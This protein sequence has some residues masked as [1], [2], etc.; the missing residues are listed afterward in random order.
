VLLQS[1]VTLVNLAGRRLTVEGEK[2]LAQAKQGIDAVRA[3]LP[4]CPE[5]EVAPVKEAM[6][7]L[8]MLYVRETR[9]AAGEPAPTEP[10]AAEPGAPSPATPPSADEEARAKARAK[11]WTPPGAS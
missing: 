8:Q 1:V 7:Q 6:S 2:D 10:S 9:G 4:L 11:I 5:R 3:L